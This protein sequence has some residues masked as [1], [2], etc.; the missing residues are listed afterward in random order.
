MFPMRP[1]RR[2]RDLMNF[3]GVDDWFKDFFPVDLVSELTWDIRT[4]I[5][6]N[7]NE[8]IIEAEIPGVDKDE[9][10]LELKNQILTLSAQKSTM[11]ED[12][13]DNYIRRERKFGKVSRSFYVD[14]VDEKAVKAD[15]KDGVLRIVLPKIRPEKPNTYQ[16]PIE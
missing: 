1:F 16:I 4:D 9:L 14:N 7:E 11:N 5:R 12:K 8:Y 2:G 10:H 6:E 15:Y 13:N 3:T